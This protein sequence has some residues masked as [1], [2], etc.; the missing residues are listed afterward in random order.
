MN[1]R[2]V[3]P[4]AVFGVWAS[5][6]LVAWVQA[7]AAQAHLLDRVVAV[8][9]NEVITAQEINTHLRAAQAQLQSRNIRLPERSALVRQVLEQMIVQR[10]QLQWARETGVRVSDQTVNAAIARIAE[11][12]AISLSDMQAQLAQE[13]VSFAQYREDIRNE[14]TLSRLRQREVEALIQVTEGEVDNYLAE[15]AGIEAGTVE[16][17]LAQIL[18][19]V[20]EGATTEQIAE[21]E[22]KAKDLMVQLEAGADFAQ[23]A[24]SHSAAPEALEGGLLEWRSAQRLPVL[25][26]EALQRV[27][28]GGL[29]PIVRSPGGFH[30]LKLRGK[31]NAAE[32]HHAPEAVQQTHVRHILLRVSEITPET[33]V[34]RRLQELR[35]RMIRGGQEFGQL[36][37]LHSVDGS[38]TRGGDLGWI[39]PGDTV[40]EFERAMNALKVNE[41]SEPVQS[42]FGWHLIQV[43]E[44]RTEGSPIERA[45]LQA[46]LTLRQRKAD[47]Q[48]QDWL[49]QL[50]DRTYVEYRLEDF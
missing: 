3:R 10:A 11:Q 2:Y 26:V 25:F 14:I 48:F 9:N 6:G 27:D 44:R 31:R 46:R 8:V 21:I 49:R 30:I 36:A 12:N 19:R 34:K 5:L 37:R 39:N 16:Y 20:P 38:S 33:E 29:A 17:Q 18:L 28:V 23:L 7:A 40:P 47:E 22:K 50:R 13:G 1:L 24:A 45:R 15:Q 43:L 4:L 32:A 41:I 35:D 42:P